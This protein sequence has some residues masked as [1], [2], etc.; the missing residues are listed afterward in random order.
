MTFWIVTA[1][2]CLIV[3]AAVGAVLVR[4]RGRG[5]SA[6]EYDLQVYRD[7]M[8]EVDRDLARGVL[9][10]EEAQRLKLEV[11]RRI[12]EADKAVQAG[13]AGFGGTPKAA[14]WAGAALAAVML[15][16]GTF[17]VYTQL[18][19]PGYPDL[20]L[21]RRIAIAEQA[22]AERPGQGVAEAEAALRNPP[23]GEDAFDAE[24]LD[25]VRRLREVVAER[26]DDLRG[27]Q[28]LARQ[29]AGMG[30]FA[31]AWK[32]QSR[33]VQ[34]KGEAATAADF[35]DL[36]DMMVLAAGGYVSPE[37]EAVLN[38]ALQRD[39]T[40]GVAR[41][42]TG[43]MYA[44]TGRPDVAFRIWSQQLAQSAPDAPWQDPIRA[45]IERVAME[46]GVD[47]TPPPRD[48]GMNAPF[49]NGPNQA[50]IDAAGE[51][52]AADRMAMIEGMVGGLAERLSSEGGTAEE[53]AR[54]IRAYGVLGRTEDA[55]RA[56]AAAQDAFP[57]DITRVPILQ[58]ARDAGVEQ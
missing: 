24:Y 23:P 3:L 14:A 44:Q 2:L 9:A 25:L 21:E 36:A 42:Y 39:S 26:P 18:G 46:A 56:W 30:R 28:L 12:L 41:Y 17:A 4:G 19:A 33:Y 10:D 7:Q 34:L 37:A 45:Q 52:S 57:D 13:K 50:Q 58:A 27:V 22:R 47:Y 5:G 49:L 40:N 54:L 15:V 51:M 32:A 35:A 1:A 53:W 29:E 8:K 43:L 55:A 20:P 11:S 38:E 16:G 48:G 31:D 6:A